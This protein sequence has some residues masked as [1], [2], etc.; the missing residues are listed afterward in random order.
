MQGRHASVEMGQGVTIVD[1]ALESFPLDQMEPFDRPYLELAEFYARSGQL[2]RA[3]LMLTQFA[4]EVPEEF[5]VL[6]D[7]EFQRANAFLAMAEGRTDE[8]LDSFKRSHQPSCPVCVL[9][10][11]AQLYDQTGNSDSLF[12]VLDRYVNTPDDDRFSR[13]ALELPG[14]YVRLGEL[15]EA[16]G[17]SENAIDYYNR[18]TDLW[19]NADVE[20]Q[21]QVDDV[22]RRIERLAAESGTNR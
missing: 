3:R 7:A 13:D 11:L 6:T 5:R 19:Q 1:T 15:Y 4:S 2:D 20:L 22:R 21:P 8:A 17:D 9:P 16:R 18:F 12:A 10:G 14:A